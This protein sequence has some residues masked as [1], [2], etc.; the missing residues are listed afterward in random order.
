MKS[1]ERF[2]LSLKG[3]KD[4][5]DRIACV[6]S[7]SVSTVEFMKVTDAHW[8]AAHKNA[9]KM[10]RL[11]SAAHRLCGLDNISVPFCM[12]VEAEVL[13]ARIDFHEDKI[14]WPSVREFQVKEP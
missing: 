14:K 3:K 11:G 8:P 2:M 6:N 1:Y 12:T 7:A 13:G 9:A 4:E 10:A 5:A